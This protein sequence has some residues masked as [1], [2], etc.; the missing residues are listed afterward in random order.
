MD[1]E[2]NNIVRFYFL[3]TTATLFLFIKCPDVLTLTYKT[4]GV[5]YG[6]P[7]LRPWYTTEYEWITVPKWAWVT[8]DKANDAV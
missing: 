4:E 5:M 1:K 3:I 8:P 6:L 7:L 2:L